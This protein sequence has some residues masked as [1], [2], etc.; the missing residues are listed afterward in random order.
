MTLRID[1]E[2]PS[3]ITRPPQS[4][5]MASAGP[6]CTSLIQTAI[7]MPKGNG[8]NF[9]TGRL[10]GFWDVVAF[11]M[12]GLLP[13]GL[14]PHSRNPT[15]NLPN[16]YSHNRWYRIWGQIRTH[17]VRCASI[18]RRRTKS[19]N[20]IRISAAMRTIKIRS[21]RNQ[22]SAIAL[23]ELQNARIR[24]L[25]I[26]LESERLEYVPRAIGGCVHIDGTRHVFD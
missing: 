4:P 18:W 22:T 25:R 12:V 9:A 14:R 2:P 20:V 17:R 3:V 15:A 13:F 21:R 10:A 1:R 8:P 16:P 19:Q 23:L 5:P 7:E 24:C 26:V 6:R 11:A